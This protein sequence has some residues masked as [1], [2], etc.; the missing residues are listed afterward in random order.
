[1]FPL[2]EWCWSRLTPQERVPYYKEL[3]LSWI[4]PVIKPSL[5]SNNIPSW[6]D[7]ERAVLA[8]E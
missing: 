1:M 6:K 8:G 7:V 5:V 2:D 4:K 3:W